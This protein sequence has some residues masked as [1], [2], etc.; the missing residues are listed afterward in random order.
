[1]D[2]LHNRQQRVVVNG[3]SDWI[4]VSSGILQGSV[5]GLVRFLIYIKN[6]P[7]TIHNILKLFGEDTKLFGKV[8]TGDEAA[9]IQDTVYRAVDWS[10]DW[11]I[12]F[13]NTKGQHMHLGPEN[14]FSKYYMASDKS[15]EPIVTVQVEKDLGVTFD[16][17]LKFSLHIQNCVKMANRNFRF[18]RI[19][20]CVKMANRNLGFV[21]RTFSYLIRLISA[22]FQITCKAT[23]SMDLVFGQ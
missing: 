5:L 1:M 20:N 23:L 21:R 17:K 9:I 16:N 6:L 4:Q 2:F 7:D 8:N 10:E 12:H 14:D 22:S 15:G 13:N 11:Q 3:S 19:Q 18:I